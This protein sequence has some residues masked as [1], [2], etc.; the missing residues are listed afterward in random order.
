MNTD[1]PE[2]FYAQIQA[3]QYKL[4]TDQNSDNY[5]DYYQ[6]LAIIKSNIQNQID[7]IIN[8]QPVKSQQLFGDYKEMYRANYF[9]NL[10]LFL[11]I[12]LILWYIIK[13]NNKT[14]VSPTVDT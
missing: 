13:G 9:T 2:Y 8:E 14:N 7:L 1:T 3:I 6:E 10:C 5:Q 4:Q 12:C 11:G